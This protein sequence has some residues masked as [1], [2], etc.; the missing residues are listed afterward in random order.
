MQE[1]PGDQGSWEYQGSRQAGGGGG[2]GVPGL[3]FGPSL[4]SLGSCG[5][6]SHR[7]Q[8]RPESLC[9]APDPATWLFPPAGRPAPLGFL[10]DLGRELRELAGG[11]ADRLRPPPVGL[12]VR[13][14]GS[15]SAL[16]RPGFLE[17]G[18]CPTRRE[19]LGEEGPPPPVSERPCHFYALFGHREGASAHSGEIEVNGPW[20]FF[21]SLK[22]PS[23]FFRGN[24][25]PPPPQT[26]PDACPGPSLPS[27]VRCLHLLV[28]VAGGAGLPRVR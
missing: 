12:G 25:G 27:P 28:E 14:S 9:G 24:T 23:C 4:R 15:G 22:L 21:F 18:T 3:W 13:G 2:V 11:R 20:L 17:A 8:P 7:S 6:G 10:L 19:E 26:L 1:K 16:L 5:G